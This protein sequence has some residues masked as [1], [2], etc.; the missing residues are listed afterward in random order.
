MSTAQDHAP[1]GKPPRAR[2][3][4]L[5]TVVLGF[6]ALAA[7]AGWAASFIGLHAFGVSDMVGYTDRTAWLIPAAFD[8]AAFACAALT[9]R[10]SIAGRS[11]LRGRLLTWAFTALSSWINYIHQP[12]G[13]E[14]EVSQ[15]RLVA[16]WLPIAAVAVF[17][18]V[19]SEM[20]ADWEEAHGRKAFR[21]RLGLLLLRALVDRKGTSAAFREQITGIPVSGLVGLGADLKVDAPR[22]P[23]TAAVAAPEVEPAAVSEV[24]AFP[25][26]EPAPAV[27]PTPVRAPVQ[28]PHA[29]AAPA[30][31]PEVV[32]F[33]DGGERPAWL[34]D[35]MSARDAMFRYCVENPGATGVEVD[36]FGM[37]HLGTKAD[38]GR[39][40]LRQFKQRQQADDR[41]TPVALEG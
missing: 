40:I 7:V 11:A 27:E 37:K 34:A 18:V 6:V 8:G 36:R 35:G 25:N 12:A 4:N 41:A 3:I 28:L 23:E 19:L 20:R 1:T 5:K 22:R 33:P 38:Y 32:S 26:P 9:Y 21:M 39:K 24:A 29:A 31:T 13:A 10:A 15:A 2:R 14:N 17:D 30:P 16:V